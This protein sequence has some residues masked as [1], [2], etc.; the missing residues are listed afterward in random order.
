MMFMNLSDIAILNIKVFD[1]RCIIR[2]ISKSKAIN[3]MQYADFTEKKGNIIKHKHSLSQIKMGKE[4]L[5]FW[6]IEIDKRNFY[7]HESPTF[8]KDV[9]IEKVLVSNRISFGEKNYK[10][11]IGYLYNDPHVKPLHMLPKTSPDVKSYDGQIKWMY[12]LIEGDD[13]LK[14]YNTIF[15]YRRNQLICPR[16]I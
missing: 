7:R 6:D 11:F 3:L 2:E 4:I 9:D 10:Y 8:L 14:K 15:E 1:Y 13:L 5:T 12:F 16:H